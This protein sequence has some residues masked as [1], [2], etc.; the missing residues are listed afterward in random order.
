MLISAIGIV[1]DVRRCVTMDLKEAGNAIY[2]LGLT[3]DELGG[4]LWT[5]ING[6]PGGRVPR[7]DASRAPRLFRALHEAMA[8][9]WCGVATM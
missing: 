9:D 3:R 5:E 8:A 7:V 6:R 1:P 2:V 4:S